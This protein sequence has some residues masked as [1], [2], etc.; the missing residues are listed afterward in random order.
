MNPGEY[1]PLALCDLSR[2]GRFLAAHKMLSLHIQ[3][4]FLRSIPSAEPSHSNLGGSDPDQFSPGKSHPGVFRE[5]LVQQMLG[6]VLTGRAFFVKRYAFGRFGP[7]CE[8]YM[9]LFIGSALRQ[10]CHLDTAL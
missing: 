6:C 8:R 5:H 10:K 1:S 9:L 4:G 3:C 7:S 2:K